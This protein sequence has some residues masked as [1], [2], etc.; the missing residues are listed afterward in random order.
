MEFIGLIGNRGSFKTCNLTRILAEFAKVGRPI[1]ANYHLNFPSQYNIRYMGFDALASLAANVDSY[2]LRNA[3]IGMDELGKGADSYEFFSKRSNELTALAAEL[4]KDSAI[5]FYTVQRF[6][7]IAKRLRDLT[8]V[9]SLHEDIDAGR[10]DHS[11]ENCQGI[12]RILHYDEEM[13]FLN[14]EYFDG[15]PWYPYYNTRQ[16]IRVGV[17][18]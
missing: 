17:T 4:R 13:R 14:E 2:D 11:F 10:P 7:M 3:V 18:K 1:I 5:C 9:F 6:S 8:D 12:A 16:K 15:K